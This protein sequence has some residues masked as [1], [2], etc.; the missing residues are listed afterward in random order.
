MIPEQDMQ[1]SAIRAQG[2]GGQNVNKVASAVSLSFNIKT[3]SLDDEVKKRMLKLADRRITAEGVVMIKAQRYRSFEK[4][5]ADAIL[6]LEALIE[7]ARRVDKPRR[8]TKPGKAA[9]TRRLDQKSRHSQTKALR[10]KI[11]Y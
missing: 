11:N 2:A 4:N 3:S 10:G 5:R 7:K 8:P 9:R 1:I 6:R